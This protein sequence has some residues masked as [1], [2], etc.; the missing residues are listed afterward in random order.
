MSSTNSTKP[1]PGLKRASKTA[2]LVPLVLTMLLAAGCEDDPDASLANQ[3][4]DTPSSSV[5]NYGPSGLGIMP[6]SVTMGAGSSRDVQFEAVSGTP[7]YRWRVARSD[8]GS[9]SS[10][11]L[12]M[13]TTAEGQNTITLTDSDGRSVQAS[14]YQANNA[15]SI[16][17]LSVIPAGSSLAVDKQYQITFQA[18]GGLPPYTWSVSSPSLG[19]INSAGLYTSRTVTGDNTVTV[20]DSNGSLAS[21]TVEQR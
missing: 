17:A 20:R 8:L 9:I 10:A 4:P 16:P 2:C 7:P 6:G 5:A 3:N 21:A 13:A 12:Y 14:I 15:G 11:G 1:K 18:T 19:T